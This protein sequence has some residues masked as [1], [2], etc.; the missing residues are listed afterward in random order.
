MKILLEYKA[1]VNFKSSDGST[2]LHWATM[3]AHKDVVQL[4]LDNN[5]DVNAKATNGWTPL[6]MATRLPE[7]KDIAELLQQHGGHE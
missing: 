2:P 7:H 1:E 5:A 6:H 4:L 3:M